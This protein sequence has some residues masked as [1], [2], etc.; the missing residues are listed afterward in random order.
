MSQTFPRQIP[1][2]G[3]TSIQR[4]AFWWSLKRDSQ[5]QLSRKNRNEYDQFWVTLRI[6]FVGLTHT[7][8]FL[9]THSLGS[10]KILPKEDQ[11]RYIQSA[12]L[13]GVES[14]IESNERLDV[15][16]IHID[17]WTYPFLKER[18]KPW[19]KQ[20]EEERKITR[21]QDRYAMIFEGRR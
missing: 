10:M 1:A 20:K 6:K 8:L 3:L 21:R 11:K 2:Q 14:M 18:I 19:L 13:D 4:L 5:P 12:W 7:R 9:D 17:Y 15:F 16:E